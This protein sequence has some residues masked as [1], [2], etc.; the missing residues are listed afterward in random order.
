M[1]AQFACLLNN[2][3]ELHLQNKR[4][5]EVKT[6]FDSPAGKQ[7]STLTLRVIAVGALRLVERQDRPSLTSLHNTGERDARTTWNGQL[8][9]EELTAQTARAWSTAT[10]A[11]TRLFFFFFLSLGI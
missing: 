10:L 8:L 4:P 1:F 5:K 3:S 7:T 6:A 2:I 11:R 9:R